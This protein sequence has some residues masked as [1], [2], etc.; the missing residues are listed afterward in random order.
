MRWLS[1]N[2]IDPSDPRNAALMELL[3][4]QEAQSGSAMVRGQKRHGYDFCGKYKGRQLAGRCVCC[5]VRPSGSATIG[6]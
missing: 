2:L 1:V 5:A 4:A 6:G 3:K